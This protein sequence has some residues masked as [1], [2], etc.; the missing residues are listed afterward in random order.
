ML[1]LA[2]RNTKKLVREKVK[3]S[4]IRLGR[5]FTK[6]DQAALLASYAPKYEK[7]EVFV[8]DPGAGTGILAA[9]AI[10]E[11]AKRS[12]AV[13]R[14][15]VFAYETDVAFLPMLEDNLERIRKKLFHDYKVRLVSV[16]RNENYVTAA[17]PIDG[18][19]AGG[20]DLV[21]C[22]PP[23]ALMAVRSEEWRVAKKLCS[24]DTDLCYL[25]A[26]QA[27]RDLAE[28]GR[29]SLVLPVSFA[30]SAYLDKIRRFILTETAIL[31]LHL[32]LKESKDDRLLDDARKNMLLSLEKTKAAP[33][34]IRITTSY[35]DAAEAKNVM[36]A[37]YGSIVRRDTM[38]LLLIKSEEEAKILQ[39]VSRFPA[40]LSSL[41][42]KMKTGLT[43]ESRYKSLLRDKPTPNTVPLIH[44]NS[45]QLGQIAFPHPAVKNQ[46]LVA[47]E[48][49]ILQ[50]NK[51]MLFIK[52][53]PAKS[54][55]KALFC[56]AYLASQLPRDRY[57]S[58]H[59]KLN[60]IDYADNREMDFNMVYGLFVVLNSSLYGKYYQIVSKSKQINATEFADLP[61]PS[62]AALRTLG[63]NLA[64]SRTFSEKACDK[65]LLNQMK[66]GKL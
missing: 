20:F 5:L 53:V 66:S 15:V 38:S 64:L 27:V 44:P 49:S 17:R 11:I 57:I 7:E 2:V 24:G 13:R 41:G 39:V 9:A 36:H 6:K 10:E 34:M 52:R 18:A 19:P 3:E 65:L 62:A 61:L 21:L 30:S 46:Y 22:N 45:I 47:E 48:R 50:K 32:F 29:L 58:T 28:G 59:N 1:G 26:V 31:S 43:I 8:L 55:K 51:N 33:K 4:N 25:F 42:L 23:R 35:G 12:P 56:G 60:Y 63:G 40:T 16:I 14:I 37:D 54:D